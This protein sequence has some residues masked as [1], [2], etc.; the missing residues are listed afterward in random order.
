MRGATPAMS[1]CVL[2]SERYEVCVGWDQPMNTFFAQVLDREIKG[3]DHERMIL[4]TG[5]VDRRTYARPDALIRMV[6]RYACPHHFDLVRSALLRDMYTENEASYSL[7]P[8][9]GFTKYDHCWRLLYA[10]IGIR[11]PEP[12]I[13]EIGVTQIPMSKVID[14]L[15]KPHAA[16]SAT[17]IARFMHDIEAHAMPCYLLPLESHFGD[18][19]DAGVVKW[20]WRDAGKQAGIE[21]PERPGMTEFREPND[22][23]VWPDLDFVA[24]FGIVIR[25]NTYRGW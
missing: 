16:N 17:R 13:A 1:R 4:W 9:P 15:Q 14:R 25:P 8:V 19:D 6:H 3:E 24:Q 11:H 7:L 23:R 2:D 12:L 10:L 18:L 5:G 20:R 22:W 21:F